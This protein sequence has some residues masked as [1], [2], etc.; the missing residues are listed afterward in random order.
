ML[1]AHCGSSFVTP[2]ELAA[3]PTPPHTETHFPIPHSQ[4]RT[5]IL[6]ELAD[7]QLPFSDEAIALNS[8]GTQAFGMLRLGSDNGNDWRFVIGWRNAHD[9]SFACS[10]AFGSQCSGV[11]QPG[12]PR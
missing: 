2:E 9:K 4:V 10:L 8:K 1:M 12:L 6:R 5:L 3:A 11:R 7:R